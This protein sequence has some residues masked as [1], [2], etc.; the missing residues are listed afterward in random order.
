MHAHFLPRSSFGG[1]DAAEQSVKLQLLLEGPGR[2]SPHSEE[3][4]ER[5]YWS[6]VLFESDL[7][8]EVVLPHSGIVQFE[9]TIGLLGGFEDEEDSVEGMNFGTSL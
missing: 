3:L 7:L 5:V 2:I 6:A 4:S 9:D 8:A 1:V